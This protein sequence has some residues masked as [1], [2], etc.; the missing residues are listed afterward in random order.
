ME[1][2]FRSK[3]SSWFWLC[4][5][6]PDLSFVV[7]SSFISLCKSR[8]KLFRS[9]SLQPWLAARAGNIW[10]QYKVVLLILCEIYLIFVNFGTPP[11]VCN[12]KAKMNQNYVFCAEISSSEDLFNDIQMKPL[13]RPSV[14]LFVSRD[15]F[16]I[17]QYVQ[18]YICITKTN[19]LFE[20]TLNKD[21]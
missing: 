21:S 1:F 20:E 18:S 14:S 8:S 4:L 5:T 17:L 2:N 7:F 11:E 19:L 10:T 13:P 15:S 3:F 16:H 6:A 12:K 9:Y